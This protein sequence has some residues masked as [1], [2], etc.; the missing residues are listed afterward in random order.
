MLRLTALL[1]VSMFLILL[2]GGRDYGQLRPGLAMAARDAAPVEPAPV[3]VAE[4]SAA[5]AED[6]ARVVEAAYEAP[7]EAPAAMTEGLSLPL[8]VQDR[9]APDAVVTNV[10]AVPTASPEPALSP[11][12]EGGVWLVTAEAVNVRE[13]PSTAEPVLDRLQRDEAVTVMW[14]DDTGWARIRIE[15]DGVEGYVFAD[16][17][18][19]TEALN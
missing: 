17:L 16:Y 9:P 6:D 5:P 3:A 1:C 18:V 10:A 7:A 8:V 19:P 4:P 13:G 15:G 14:T 2:I 12:T 11:E